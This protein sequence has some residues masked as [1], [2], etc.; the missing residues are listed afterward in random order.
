MS[1]SPISIQDM[2]KSE[3]LKKGL[4]LTGEIAFLSAVIRGAGEIS[5]SNKG[6]KFV[7]SSDNKDL[8]VSCNDIIK[9]RY[10]FDGEIEKSFKNIGMREMNVYR[11]SYFGAVAD[12]LLNDCFIINGYE[13]IKGISHQLISTQKGKKAYLKGVFL[14]CGG[15][16]T[17]TDTDAIIY[18]GKK[19]YHMEFSLNS[20]LV[21][22]D[23][24]ELIAELC[25][26]NQEIIK[27]RRNI[28][29]L[30][31]KSAQNISD[32]L[33]AM[34]ANKGVMALQE[35]MANRA[36]RNHL[37]R[38]N[39]FILANIDKSIIAARK[40]IDAI[41]AIENI[42]GIKNIDIKLQETAELRMQYPDISLNELADIS[43]SSK[44]KI[45]HRMRKILEIAK[46]IKET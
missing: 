45:N 17:P 30:Y 31:I 42:I 26:F 14:S 1:G 25:G 41:K 12:K 20:D 19:G 28:P 9:K 24:C 22:E 4:S 38:G 3:I 2:V 46:S 21:V 29:S 7:L 32:C 6:F 34:G 27:V 23:L 39:N 5:L 11:L 37:N 35:I 43:N 16:S 8:I 13:F 36:M 40:Q 15:L 18:H 44:S 33:A 10:D